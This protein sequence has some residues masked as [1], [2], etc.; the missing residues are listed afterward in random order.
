MVLDYFRQEGSTCTVPVTLQLAGD[1][2][3]FE[4]KGNRREADIEFLARITD[5]KGKVA[6]V[7]SDV[8]QVKLPVQTAEKIKTGQI[9]Y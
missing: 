7:A 3:Q 1:G 5:P 6:G 2:I 9:L 8:V 4:E